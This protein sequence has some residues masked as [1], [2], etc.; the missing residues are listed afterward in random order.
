MNIS[1]K[2]TSSCAGGG[3]Y[4]VDLTPGPTVAL[5]EEG[6]RAKRDLVS[7]MTTA[8]KTEWLLVFHADANGLTL[9]QV[10]AEL[11]AAPGMSM[12]L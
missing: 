1:F 5:T 4:S 2:L 6:A 7:A 12:T 10:R 11:E 3:H 8:E 9:A